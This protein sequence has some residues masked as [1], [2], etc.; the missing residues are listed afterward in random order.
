MSADLQKETDGD[1]KN[2]DKSSDIPNLSGVW[3]EKSGKHWRIIMIG[4]FY[5]LDGLD[6]GANNRKATGTF[7]EERKALTTWWENGKQGSTLIVTIYDSDTLQISNGDVFRRA[8][9]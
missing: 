3:T 9:I 7:N 5:S 2:K 4:N 8:K 1:C 6:F